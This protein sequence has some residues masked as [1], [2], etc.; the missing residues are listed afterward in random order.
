MLKFHHL[1][2]SAWHETLRFFGGGKPWGIMMAH[3]GYNNAIGT[4]HDWEW[5]RPLWVTIPTM[6]TTGG[7]LSH[8]LYP[9]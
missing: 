7:W 1:K 6:M 5:F 4:T 2:F 3:D 9:H 8:L